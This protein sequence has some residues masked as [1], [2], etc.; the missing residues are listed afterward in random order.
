[1][2]TFPEGT[3]ELTESY[4]GYELRYRVKRLP[5]GRRVYITVEVWMEDEFQFDQ[6]IIV[7]DVDVLRW[8]AT[9]TSALGTAL[10][11]VL[12]ESKRRI[13]ER[14]Y[15]KDSSYSFEFHR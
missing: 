3:E 11:K 14:D 9:R 6:A 1:M 15:E 8:Q 2:A 4:N 5:E 7:H 13:D 10:S 12:D